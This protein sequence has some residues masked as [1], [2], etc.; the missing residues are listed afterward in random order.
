[1]TKY[2]GSVTAKMALKEQNAK[3]AKMVIMAKDVKNAIVTTQAAKVKI[4][5][6]MD[7]V[8]VKLVLQGENAISAEV[9]NMI[10]KI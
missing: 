3:N 5:P 10:I 2:M 7:I 8:I 9:R 6:K 1:M 4:V